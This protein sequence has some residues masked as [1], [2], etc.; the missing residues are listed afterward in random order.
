METQ[1]QWKDAIIAVLKAAKAPMNYSEIA[2]QVF[3]RGLRKEQTATPAATALDCVK[4]SIQREGEHSK[5]VRV[6]RG[7]YALRAHM[8][9]PAVAEKEAEELAEGESPDEITGLV[10]AFGMSWDRAKVNW[11]KT[12]PPILGEQQAGA[13]RVNFCTQS[14]IYLLHD[15]QGVVYVGRASD[16]NLGRR[17]QQHT[18]DRWPRVGHGFHGLAC[19]QLS[20]MAH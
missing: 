8:N 17:L 4:Y 19:T 9:A 5:F 1:L 6:S 14:G 12:D 11:E 10:S 15:S 13:S 3:E 16:Q 7:V 18:S 2:K 20:R